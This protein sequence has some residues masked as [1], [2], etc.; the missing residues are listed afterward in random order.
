M[1]AGSM[2]T[3]SGMGEEETDSELIGSGFAAKP[4]EIECFGLAQRPTVYP[5]IEILP[6]CR[7]LACF[8]GF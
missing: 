1:F 5:L 6:A 2:R 8:P 7:P 3:D 4:S